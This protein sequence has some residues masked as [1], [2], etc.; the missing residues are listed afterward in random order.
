MTPAGF[1]MPASAPPT[2]TGLTASSRP[3]SSQAAP[4]PP[5]SSQAAPVVQ[6][7]SAEPAIPTSSTSAVPDQQSSAQAAASQPP[8][9]SLRPGSLFPLAGHS[10]HLQ[11]PTGFSVPFQGLSQ[12]Q[13]AAEGVAPLVASAGLRPLP[14]PMPPGGPAIS[15]PAD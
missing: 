2:S 7:G 13:V 10:V 3:S 9:F 5:S 12:P 4:A 6:N 14:L 15:L 11:G 8:A 1:S